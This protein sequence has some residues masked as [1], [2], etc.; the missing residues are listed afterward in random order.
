MGSLVLRNPLDRGPTWRRDDQYSV[1]LAAMIWLLVVLMIVPEGFDYESLMHPGTPGSG[2]LIS[3]L[4]WFGLLAISI[5]VISARAHLA[6]LLVRQLNPF[7]LLFFLLAIAS[8][9]WSI[10]SSLTLRRLIRLCLIMLACGAFVLMSWHA[11]RYQNVLRPI[12]T[13][14]LVGSIIFGLVAPELAIHRENSAELAGAWRG[15]ANHKNGLGALACITLILWFHA[16]LTRAVKL[17]PALAGA[18]IACTCLVLSRSSTALATSVFVLLFMLVALRPPLALRPY[19]SSLVGILVAALLIYA[20]AI[21]NIIPGLS[22]LLAPVLALSGKDLTFS[23]RTEIWDILSEHILLRPWFGSGYGAYW[24]AGAI[25]GT[26]SYAFMTRMQ[27]FY[28]GS[29]HN[30]YLEILNDLGW[31]GLGCLLA[32]MLSYVRQSLRLLSID[33]D[34]AV[35]YLALFFQQAI[36]NLSESHWLSVLS[37][38]FILMTLATMALARGLLEYRL[39]AALGAPP[40]LNPVRAGPAPPGLMA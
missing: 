29:A 32:Y 17:L 18:A 35:L 6:R 24:T 40:A 38:D 15:L 28:P 12:L 25:A 30:G 7:L 1:I 5:S 39:R 20:L 11:R 21:L 33:R 4:L 37:I 3:R 22:T 8:I 36:S 19:V 14:M 23:G 9:S 2:S 16:G 10:D 26:E 13:L 31:V 27:S 34:Q